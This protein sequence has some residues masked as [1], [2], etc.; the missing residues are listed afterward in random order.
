[1]ENQ[2]LP[3][4]LESDEDVSSVYSEDQCD[5]PL[6]GHSSYQSTGYGLQSQQSHKGERRN[7]RPFDWCSC[8]GCVASFVAV[9]L[10]AAAVAIPLVCVQLNNR[11][12]QEAILSW[13]PKET[14]KVD[15]IDPIMFTGFHLNYESKDTDYIASAFLFDQCPPLAPEQF[16][17]KVRSKTVSN[18]EAYIVY[19]YLRRGSQVNVSFCTFFSSH[20]YM[21]ILKGEE[22]YEKWL[23]FAELNFVQRWPS[24]KICPSNSPLHSFDVDDDDYYF[25]LLIL[26]YFSVPAIAT[27]SANFTVLSMQYN[28][29]ALVPKDHCMVNSTTK[30]CAIYVPLGIAAG[31][32]AVVALDSSNTTRPYH[33]TGIHI[34]HDRTLNVWLVVIISLSGLVLVVVVSILTVCCVRQ[35]YR[36]RL[37]K[38]RAAGELAIQ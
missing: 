5:A 24:S 13:H 23:S 34:T 8:I 38:R 9:I 6:L 2:K 15:D 35:C 33:Y 27:A 7:H 37:A 4:V 11:Q 19:F 18:T 20:Y 26:D 16:A 10:V 17:F 25:F 22:N 1:M 14:M 28:T 30:E 29:S 36:R 12:A 31:D 32:C 3:E 21:Y